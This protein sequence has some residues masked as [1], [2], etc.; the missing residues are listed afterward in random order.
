MGA[1]Q[2]YIERIVEEGQRD[3]ANHVATLQFHG[4]E[5]WAVTWAEPGTSINW[6]DFVFWRGALFVRGDLGEAVY[7]LS[8]KTHVTPVHVSPQS[9]VNCALEKWLRRCL[10][11]AKG[12]DPKDWDKA[13]TLEWIDDRADTFAQAH[14]DD[15]VSDD[16]FED[17][18]ELLQQL[19]EVAH[20]KQE[21]EEF[22]REHYDGDLSH[23][24]ETMGEEIAES[25]ILEAGEV[26]YR[27]AI[28]HWLGVRLA[29]KSLGMD[30]AGATW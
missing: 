22:V 6:I 8:L 14:A 28:L 5:Y 23:F 12:M 18:K 3:F 13:T 11:S 27:F 7:G 2:K 20:G 16:E 26:P 1:Y 10:A 25:G 24:F 17:A 21:W 29:L 9:V 15:D 4:P 19:R 30:K